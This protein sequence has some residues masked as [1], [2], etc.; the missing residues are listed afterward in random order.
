M[1]NLYYRISNAFKIGLWAFRNPQTINDHNFRM[2]SDLLRLILKVAAESKPVMTKIGYIHPDSKEQNDIVTI[3]AGSGL[4][5]D[6]YDRITE[7][8]KE[9]S[10]LRAQLL[11]TVK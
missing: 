5:A 3:W 4:G 2:L 10:M 1:K 8:K 11:S 9:I 7:L 6:P